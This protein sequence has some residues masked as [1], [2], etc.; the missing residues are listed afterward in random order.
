MTMLSSRIDLHG[1]NVD[2]ALWELGAKIDDAFMS[3][4]HQLEI[5]HGKGT[6]TLRKA[7]ID[8]IK[9]HPSIASY[10]MGKATEGGIGAT[11]AT[12]NN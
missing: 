5:I 8:Y 2:E 6:G 1:K 10:R 11:I 3:G 7:V 4:V 12:L 9:N